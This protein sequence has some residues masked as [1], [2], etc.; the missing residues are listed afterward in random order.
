MR[1]RLRLRLRLGLR[2]PLRQRPRLGMKLAQALALRV[3]LRAE[4][5]RTGAHTLQQRGGVTP[6]ASNEGPSPSWHPGQQ[7]GA[8]AMRPARGGGGGR[9]GQPLVVQVHP[10]LASTSRAGG[11]AVPEAGGCLV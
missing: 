1:L 3:A 8:N 11:V 5:A 9:G 6:P 10:P 2:L 4:L 7:G